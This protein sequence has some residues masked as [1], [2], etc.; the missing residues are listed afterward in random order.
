MNCELGR[1]GIVAA[2]FPPLEKRLKG[3]L[4][5][6]GTKGCTL[7]R[8]KGSVLAFALVLLTS[9]AYPPG[10]GATE[11]ASAKDSRVGDQPVIV[12]VA[13]FNGDGKPDLAVLNTGSKNVSM[14]LGSGDGTFQAATNFDVGGDNPGSPVVADFN[15]DGRLDLAVAI[16]RNIPGPAGCAQSTVNLVRGNGDGTFQPPQQAVSVNSG[17]PQVAVGDLNGDGSPD[18]VVR[19]ELDAS[20]PAAGVSIF[21]GNGDGTFQAASESASA[22]LPFPG[23]TDINGDGKPDFVV[24]SQGGFFVV[25][26]DGN[27]NPILPPALP[28]SALGS[29]RAIGDFNG[30]QQ[31]DR[32]TLFGFKQCTF[33]PTE[34]FVGVALDGGSPVTY[35]VG[36]NEERVLAVGDFNHDAKP[37]LAVVHTGS[38]VRTLLNNGAGTFSNV[39]DFDIGSGPDTFVVADLNGDGLPDLATANVNDDTAS[40]VLNTS[41]TSGAD[42]AVLNAASP[43]PVSVTQ[44][45]TYTISV[46]N[47]GPQDATSLRLSDTLPNSVNFVSAT[48]SQ[49]SCIESHLVV[50]CDFGSMVSGASASSTIVVVPTATGTITNSTS[51]TAAEADLRSANNSASQSTQVHPMFTLKVVK[52]GSGSGTVVGTGINC[53]TTCSASLPTGTSLTLEAHPDAGSGFG[54]WSGECGIATGC[55]LTMNADQTVTATFDPLPNFILLVAVSTLTV[56]RG[57][58]VT[59]G[60]TIVP[61]GSSFDSAISLSCEVAGPAP[62]P[63]CTLSPASLTPGAN[64]AASTLTI[65][66]P[67]TSAQLSPPQEE[68]RPAPLYALWLPLPGIAL[69]GLGLTARKSRERRRGLCLLFG[70]LVALCTLEAACGGGGNQPSPPAQRGSQTYTVTITATSG[71]IQKVATVAL[72]VQ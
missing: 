54:G 59:D 65:T 61:E 62:K 38:L 58:T 50:S 15:R 32:A 4:P 16:P 71:T 36:D 21:L 19:R 9:L 45:L 56:R 12:L 44:N 11:F 49:G 55:G 60:I 14:L 37:D 2:A 53:G 25:V 30:N 27:P 52:A 67:A 5:R 66:A 23:F 18:L 51:V 13:D 28:P 42:L 10:S 35:D 17:R 29:V 64:F 1:M 3:G 47:S 22:D 40:V 8:R 31:M 57:G 70:L 24:A 20:C 6:G 33:C 39:F 43:D 46:L 69:F 72:T 34:S 26:G 41:P 48:A 7:M 63:T 68:Y